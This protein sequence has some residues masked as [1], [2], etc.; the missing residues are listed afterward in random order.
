M[1]S[2][3]YHRK[4]QMERLRSAATG[5][6]TQ[7]GS[8]TASDESA[9]TAGCKSEFVTVVFDPIPSR[10]DLACNPMHCIDF[11]LAQPKQHGEVG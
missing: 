6:Q 4:A 10:T 7:R 5:R 1:L 3:V 9:A 8:W 2:K 11:Q